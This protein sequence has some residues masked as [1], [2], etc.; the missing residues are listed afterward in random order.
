MC[1]RGTDRNSPGTGVGRLKTVLVIVILIRP[2]ENVDVLAVLNFQIPCFR[3][4][5]PALYL[6]VRS[7]TTKAQEKNYDV[8]VDFRDENEGLKNP[9]QQGRRRPE[10][11]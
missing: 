8:R 4:E 7:P 10:E 1:C 3:S 2:P 9:G 5:T 11:P 6:E